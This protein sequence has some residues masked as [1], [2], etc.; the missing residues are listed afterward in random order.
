MEGEQFDSSLMGGF[1]PRPMSE[2]LVLYRSVS[3]H[4]LRDIYQ[5]NLIVGGGNLFN[6]F[7][8]RHQVFFADAM[9]DRVI[10]QGEYLDRQVTLALHDHE[11]SRRISLA[12]AKVDGQVQLI[13][14]E[15][16]AAGIPYD[17]DPEMEFEFRW[18]IDRRPIRRA[19]KRRGKA[20]RS[21]FREL[22]ASLEA[23]ERESA[24]ADAAQSAIS[25]K[26][27][28]DRA[29][30]LSRQ[31]YTSAVL[32][33]YPLLGGLLYTGY[34]CLLGEREYGFE[35]GQVTLDDVAEVILIRFQKEVGRCAPEDLSQHL[36]RISWER[37]YP[38]D[39]L[40]H[41]RLRAQPERY[42]PKARLLV[43]DGHLHAGFNGYFKAP[44]LGG[45]AAHSR[46]ISPVRARWRSFRR[47]KT[48]CA[49]QLE[50]A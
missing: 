41:P 20:L 7:D 3:L 15:M 33:T 4:E 6:L 35:P 50:S 27:L 24:A 13:L 8:P 1:K 18:D 49:R 22:F 42:D 46:P 36:Q 37:P 11:S 25:E 16:R 26:M 17:P 32:V 34:S 43:H 14:A 31:P 48:L 10:R 5:T 28:K 47:A 29:S 39:R 19:I 30:W 23:A 45:M 44:K 9:E 12:H 2:S 21:R 40:S 38:A